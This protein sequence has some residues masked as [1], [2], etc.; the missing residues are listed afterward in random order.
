MHR[1]KITG[2]ELKPNPS[3]HIGMLNAEKC[4]IYLRGIGVDIDDATA[5]SWLDTQGVHRFL[6]SQKGSW[7][8]G[9]AWS[10][11]C[12]ELEKQLPAAASPVGA[13]SPA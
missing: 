4:V 9:E 1:R 6:R 5:D 2:A 3:Q 7:R 12:G 11:G 8:R 13:G 10:C